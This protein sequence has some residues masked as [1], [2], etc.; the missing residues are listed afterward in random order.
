MVIQTDYFASII[1]DVLLPV[2]SIQYSF[3]FGSALSQLLPQSDIDVLIGGQI[4]ADQR[5]DIAIALSIRLK[6]TVDLVLV[7]DA[8]CDI[9]MKAMSEGLLV[10]VK[11]NESLKQDYITIWRQFDDSAELRRIKID[12]IKL[13]YCHGR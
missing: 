5:M 3:L 10:F 1:T 7:R 2:E 12:R 4:T 6:R 11:D 13:Q 9:V 8:H